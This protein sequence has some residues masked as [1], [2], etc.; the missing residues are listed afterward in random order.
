MTIL[1]G[2]LALGGNDGRE[3]ALLAPRAASGNQA[4]ATEP[5]AQRATLE[6][7]LTLI[8]KKCT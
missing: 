5:A 2:G 7:V 1:A 4:Q 8:S 6:L 3:V